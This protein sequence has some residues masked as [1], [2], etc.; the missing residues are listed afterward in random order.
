[1]GDQAN[2]LSAPQS[3]TIARG[4][5][6]WKTELSDFTNSEVWIKACICGP[7]FMY[8][9]AQK[10]DEHVLASCFGG[11]T[12]LRAFYRAKHGIQGTVVTDCLFSTFLGPCTAVQLHEEIEKRGGN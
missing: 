4:G 8:E 12:A 11:L 6:E 9:L 3:N 7:C 5:E 2:E 1:M 10:I